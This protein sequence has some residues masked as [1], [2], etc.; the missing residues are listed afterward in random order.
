M[1]EIAIRIQGET[2]SRGH[3]E[4]LDENNRMLT[5]GSRMGKEERVEKHWKRRVSSD[6]F[7]A[8]SLDFVILK[9]GNLS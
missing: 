6:T 8:E 2:G 1:G 4:S 5:S 7:K 3:P 9:R